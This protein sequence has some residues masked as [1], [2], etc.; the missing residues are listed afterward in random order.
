MKVDGNVYERH[1][2][3]IADGVAAEIR[4]AKREGRVRTVWISEWMKVDESDDN[5]YERHAYVIA[6][7]VA[8]EIRGDKS[9]VTLQWLRHRFR[10][11]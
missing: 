6:N 10:S 5:V 9:G 8:A 4:G 11:L 2:Y 7:G 1:A 3:V